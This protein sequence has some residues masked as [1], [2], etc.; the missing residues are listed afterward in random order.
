MISFIAG[1]NEVSVRLDRLLRKKLRLMALSGI[2]S[3][4]R[5]GGVRV[6]GERV[7][8]DYRIQKGDEVCID[9]DPSEIVEH[10]QQNGGRFERLAR[11][12]FFKRNFVVLHEDRDILACNKPPGLVAH[13][14]SGH[15]CGDTLFDLAAAYLLTGKRIRT[16]DDMALVHR[17]DRDTSGIILIAKNKRAVRC[18]H[19][20]FRNRSLTKHYVAIC[21]D[22]PP[23][24]E[25]EIVVRLARGRDRRGETTMRVDKGGLLS[26]TRYRI[27]AHDNGLSRLELFL[28]TGR[29]HQ[30]RA[31]MAH[32]GAP[33]VGDLR[34][35][36]RARDERL[37]AQCRG[38]PER[39]Y[40]HA[41]KI[42]VP[43]P[44][45]GKMLRI[46]APLP[47]EFG[48]IMRQVEAA[49]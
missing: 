30:I 17:L 35:G 12:E 4:V 44:S 37:F 26:C 15:L 23:D 32:A 38:V 41:W 33:L 16:T 6:N 42:A 31:H 7:R 13:P 20:E 46:T 3:L 1:S 27:E 19:E 18:L 14:G 40:L 9:V 43:H 39:L 24:H 2:Y 10:H 36:D 47:V 29:M 48:E 11:T 22:R 34:Y 49:R 21:H 25:G 5:R 8:Q 45:N 28:D